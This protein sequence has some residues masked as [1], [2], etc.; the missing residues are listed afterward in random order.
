M[1]WRVAVEIWS[2]G[3]WNGVQELDCHW[4]G[5]FCH[6]LWLLGCPRDA[7]MGGKVGCLDRDWQRIRCVFLGAGF[8][9]SFHVIGRVLDEGEG[10]GV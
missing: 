1:S 8:V 4:G 2:F 9:R 5:F 7:A 6:W 10:N 3:V